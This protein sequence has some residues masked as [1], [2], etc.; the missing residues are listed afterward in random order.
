MVFVFLC[1][2]SLS[3]IIS[4]FIYVA[5]NDIISFFFHG[6]VGFHCIYVPH[7]YLFICWWTFCFHV[8]AILNSAAMNIG[9]HVSFWI[10]VLSGYMPSSRIA[11][12]YSSSIFSFLRKLHTVLHS[13]CTN[14]YF[15]QQCRR[16]PYLRAFKHTVLLPGK[17]VPHFSSGW[18]LLIFQV[19]V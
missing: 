14:L 6:W 8:L 1:L 13:G 15:H 4:R 18:F 9:V 16:V 11:G 5:A 7:L 2:T 19:S 17:L 10:I 3:M 12:S